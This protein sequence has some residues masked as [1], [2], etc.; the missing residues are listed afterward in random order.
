MNP[1]RPPKSGAGK[2]PRSAQ[3][4]MRLTH[5]QLAELDRVC[6]ELN[7]TR[8]AFVRRALKG[9]PYSSGPSG[10]LS[11]S[12]TQNLGKDFPSLPAKPVASI[13][14]RHRTTLQDGASM[15]V[16]LTS[17]QQAKLKRI[18]GAGSPW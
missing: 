11:S 8:A 18:S 12:G 1:E 7:V 14:H 16:Q 2:Q 5:S 10:R 17:D 13:Q 3:I 9:L 6:A 15:E 4:C